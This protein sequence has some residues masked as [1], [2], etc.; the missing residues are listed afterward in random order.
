MATKKRGLTRA[1]VL[2]LQ[3]GETAANVKL[4]STAKQ[5]RSFVKQAHSRGLS[6]DDYFKKTPRALAPKTQAQLQAQANKEVNA[7]YA[8]AEAELGSRES[9]VNAVSAKRERDDAYYRDWLSQQTAAISSDITRSNQMITDKLTGADE[10]ARAG[11]ANAAAAA[12]ANVNKDAGVTQDVSKGNAIGAIPVAAA[13]ADIKRTGETTR[14]LTGTALSS[15][16]VAA[17]HAN[18]LASYAANEAKRT[19]DTWKALSDI[20]GEKTKLKLS[21]AADSAKE[22]AHLLDQ[23]ISKAQSNR[24]Y[25]ALLDKLDLQNKDLKVK[26]RGQTLTA[27][28]K[29][30]DRKERSRYHTSLVQ[31]RTDDRLYRQS[32]DD[33]DRNLKRSEFTAKY[34]KTPDQWAK[35]NDAQRVEWLKRYSKAKGTGKGTKDATLTPGQKNKNY[36][37]GNQFISAVNT[38]STIIKPVVDPKT[39]QVKIKNRQKLLDQG[40]SAE[41]IDAA[42]D[43]HEGKKVGST[44]PLSAKSRAYVKRTLKGYGVKLPA[45]W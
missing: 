45:G 12:S 33:A 9:Q 38:L 23:E 7:A 1:S 24:D 39:K 14:E 30:A 35:M 8:P 6:M 37:T 4:N 20:A 31:A 34:G 32:K 26:A 36:Q 13:T 41:M 29:A 15:G 42:Y 5:W 21:K 22:V 17:T 43:I 16:M 25:G 2:A 40:Y 44:H 19:A 18:T 28:Q 3:L 27:K 11:Y 10:A